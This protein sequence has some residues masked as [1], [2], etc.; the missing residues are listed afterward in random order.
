MACPKMMDMFEQ[1]CTFASDKCLKYPHSNNF[2]RTRH[3]V[4]SLALHG[5]QIQG[6][7][8]RANKKQRSRTT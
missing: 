6:A 7:E 2:V 1:K 5:V 4:S 8:N 3:L